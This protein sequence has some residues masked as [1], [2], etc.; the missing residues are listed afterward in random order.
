MT[1]MVLYWRAAAAGLALALCTST[2]AFAVVDATVGQADQLVQANRAGEAYRLLAPLAATRAGD[3][4]FDYVLGLAAVDSGR[5]AEAIIALQRVLALQPANA[6]ARAELAR[7]YALAGDAD[8]ARREFD[9]VV[10]DPTLPDPVR[11]RFN[12][13]LSQLD[14][15]ISGGGTDVTGFAE[16][17]V[18]YDSNVNSATSQSSLVIPLFAGLGAATLSGSAVE[19]SDSYGRLDAGASVIHGL[20]RQAR[21]FASLLGSAKENLDDD[22]FDQASLTGTGGYSYT[23]AARKVISASLQAQGFWLS[24]SRY[25]DSFGGTAQVTTPLPGGAALSFAGQYFKI[26]YPTDPLRDADRY[27][28]GA[29][30]AWRQGVVSL[31]AGQET[32]DDAA[33]DQFSHRFFGA[34]GTYEYPLGA[35]MTVVGSLGGEVRDYEAAD[36]LFLVTR[37][38][39]QIDAVVGLRMKIRERLILKPQV[40]YTASSSNIALY[41]YDR[42]TAAVT[43]RAEF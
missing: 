36:P 14:R 30:Y 32:T 43:L 19:T 34:N 18:G 23:T 11:Q 3:P 41:D 12:G 8:T 13:I 33:A 20:S 38:D 29:S 1:S 2:A 22:L 5:P 24:G 21:V 17:S 15:S 40:T 39:K 6:Q 9:T 4:D 28:V 7:A 27:V 31:Q 10:G 26:K 35:G 42:V 25:R 16:A 37:K